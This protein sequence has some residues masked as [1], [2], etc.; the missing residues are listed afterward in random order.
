M[1]C[2]VYQGQGPT[3]AIL[4]RGP[5]WALL[6]GCVADTPIC[7]TEAL[8]HTLDKANPC[9]VSYARGWKS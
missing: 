7:Q 5:P 8:H 4:L 2:R 9:S 3:S 6:K 1:L